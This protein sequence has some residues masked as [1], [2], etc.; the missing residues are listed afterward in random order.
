MSEDLLSRL[1]A[2]R[3]DEERNWLVTETLLNSFPID[4]QA[5]TW[6]AAVPH[7]FDAEILAAL[8]ERPALDCV[9]LY[10]DLQNLPFVESFE[11]RGGYNIHEV[12]RAAMLDHLW[13]QRHQDYVNFSARAAGYFAKHDEPEWQIEHV[14][15]L[16]LSDPDQGANTLW[17]LGAEWNN[18]FQYTLT[19]A[20]AQAGLEH[21]EAG[22]SQGRS[23]GWAY[24]R[25]GQIE[26]RYY[27]HF[28]A[29]KAFH[30][31]LQ[32]VDGDRQLEANCIKALGD[33]HKQLAEYAEARARYEEARPIYAAIG[34]RLGEANCI[35]ALGDVH[36]QLAEYAE[37]RARYEEARPIYAAIGARLGEANCDLGLGDLARREKEWLK[38]ELLFQ[39]ALNVYQEIGVPYNIGL[40]LRRLGAVS[41]G[42][43]ERVKAVR[44]YQE[45]LQIFEAIGVKDTEF[46]RK[47]LER[48]RADLLENGQA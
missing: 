36:K 18:T 47:D 9:R 30:E 17:E 32:S 45:A 44:F 35:Q 6:A 22:R 48:L 40:A 27:R 1:R 14:Y 24:F 11:D 33:V 25:H 26:S 46:T 43:E 23:R 4:L 5:A 39:A 12:T 29:I 31:A 37:A 13:R 28:Q 34:D 15:H 41:E 16:L 7:W 8:L 19:F 42:K 38:A 2:A 3:S 21:A 20:L 10:N